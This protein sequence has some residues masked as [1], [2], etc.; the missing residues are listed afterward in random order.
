MLA[1]W[2]RSI[3]DEY[4][5]IDEWLKTGCTHEDMEFAS[6]HIGAWTG[7]RLFQQALREAGEADFPTLLRAR[8]GR[9]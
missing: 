6:E 7:V 2:D 1:R 8:A 3:A 4:G 9:R 5:A